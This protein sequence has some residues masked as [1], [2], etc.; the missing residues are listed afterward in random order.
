MLGQ[1]LV[2]DDGPEALH[3]HGG[4]EEFRHLGIHAVI[5]TPSLG[6][7]K[8]QGTPMLTFSGEK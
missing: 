8:W 4:G 3:H 6:S 5:V 7:F 1:L 2:R